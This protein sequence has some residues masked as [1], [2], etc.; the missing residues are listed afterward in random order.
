MSVRV[1][2]RLFKIMRTPIK[3]DIRDVRYVDVR[4]TP[5]VKP[6]LSMISGMLSGIF[7]F[8]PPLKKHCEMKLGVLGILSLPRFH[9]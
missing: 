3:V 7:V 1:N 9:L 6:S 8:Q 2:V 4:D 5:N